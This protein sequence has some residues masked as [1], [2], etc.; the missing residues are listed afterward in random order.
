MTDGTFHYGMDPTKCLDA[1]SSV[2][3]CQVA[4][5]ENLPFWY[6]PMHA[7]HTEV[8]GLLHH[9]HIIITSLISVTQ[10]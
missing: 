8:V 3:G 9:Y 1:G 4:T 7:C 2:A 6:V 10:P 5:V